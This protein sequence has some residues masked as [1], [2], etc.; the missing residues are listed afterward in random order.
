MSQ[1]GKQKDLRTF[2]NNWRLPENIVAS[3]VVQT[4]QTDKNT[5]LNAN[6]ANKQMKFNEIAKPM[7]KKWTSDFYDESLDS[8]SLQRNK[9][10]QES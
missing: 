4:N 6:S 2:V 10:N 3:D 9:V 1:E 7:M 8:K 5:L